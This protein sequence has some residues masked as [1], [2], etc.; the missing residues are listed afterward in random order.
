MRY[1]I[2]DKREKEDSSAASAEIKKADLS[3]KNTR[4][5]LYVMAVEYNF[6]TNFLL[7]INF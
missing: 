1:L 6:E 4:C 5:S 2:S 3:C 7:V